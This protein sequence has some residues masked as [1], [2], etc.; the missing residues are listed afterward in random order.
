MKALITGVTGM[1]GALL[2]EFLLFKGY[3]V[4]GVARRTSN[5]NKINHL[6]KVPGFTLQ[7]SDI[8]N[9]QNIK[10]LL[11][12]HNPKEVYNLAAQSSVRDS[13]NNPPEYTME[14]NVRPTEH[15][16]SLALEHNMPFHFYLSTSSEM[17]GGSSTY[18]R[19]GR[20]QNEDT[21]FNP[22]SPYATSKVIAH[23]IVQMYRSYGVKA[24]TGIL[25]HHDHETR[26]EGFLVK[27]ITKWVS[28]FN[29]WLKTSGGNDYAFRN[30]DIVSAFSNETFPKLRLFNTTSVKDFGVA[31]DFVKSMWYT[32]Q[33][34]PD[35]YI[36]CA[37]NPMSVADILSIAFNYIGI[38]NWR[39]FV[40]DEGFPSKTDYIPGCSDKARQVLGWEP[41]SSFTM[42]IH[43]MIDNESKL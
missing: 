24:S 8:L 34:D 7:I 14:I 43:R 5:T 11:L 10:Q 4:I 18:T 27:K 15:F 36:I 3:E 40:I 21:P 25:Y 19:S 32:T 41:T 17:F 9:K 38:T 42:L 28:D 23:R 12:T 6:L 1:D 29:R 39:D 26:S 20:V 31:N 2:A 37:N 16:L 13:I 35:D 22:Q 30:D 33:H